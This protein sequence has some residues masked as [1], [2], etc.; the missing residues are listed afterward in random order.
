MKSLSLHSAW[1]CTDPFLRAV[2]E[3]W[4]I[5]V[6]STRFA[7]PLSA[8]IPDTELIIFE[9]CAHAPIYDNVDDFNQRTLAFL[10]R[11]SS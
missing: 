6:A 7:D 11:H 2:V 10:Q 4:R 5:M 3:G 1:P 8:A 9:D